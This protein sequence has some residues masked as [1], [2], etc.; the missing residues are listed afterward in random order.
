MELLYICKS[1]LFNVG[2]WLT[3]VVG[4]VTVITEIRKSRKTTFINT[5]TQTRKEYITKLREL[6][7]EFCVK[8]DNANAYQLKLMMNPA[9][10]IGWWD[11]EAVKLIEKI[12]ESQDKSDIDKFVALMQSWLAL[13]W[14]GIM[15]EGMSGILNKN[16]K[17]ALRKQ[18][19][20]EYKKYLKYKESCV[21]K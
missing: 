4:I 1:D 21:Q 17:G 6:T 5:V 16:K 20:L 3:F 14:H 11:D 7:A 9:G 12:I 18:F 10:F 13:E 19:Y 15:N 2:A 8:K